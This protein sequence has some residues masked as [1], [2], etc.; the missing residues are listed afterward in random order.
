MDDQQSAITES[1]AFKL[2]RA[3]VLMDRIADRYL[4]AEHGIRYSN[5]LVLLMVGALGRPGQRRIAETLDVS[6]ASITQRLKQLRDAGLVAIAPDPTDARAHTVSLTA[7][8]GALLT[9]AWVGLDT[10]QDGIDVGVDETVLAQQL[11]RL[12]ANA[13]AVL[14]S[15][16]HPGETS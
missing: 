5:F 1:T 16:R 11:D 6:S 8:G 3:T 2:H 10:H 13:V 9:A 4:F 12:I 7:R 14:N 15:T